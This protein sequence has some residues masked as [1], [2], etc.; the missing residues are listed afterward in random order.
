MFGK[1]SRAALLLSVAAALAGLGAWWG[2]SGREKP[3][4]VAAPPAGPNP[5]AVGAPAVPGLPAPVSAD[6]KRVWAP[7]TLYRYAVTLEHDVTF[8][9]GQPGTAPPSSMR[10]RIQGEWGVGVVAVS[11]DSVDARGQLQPA[12]FSMTVN[13]EEALA[14]DVRRAM[15][16]A[17]AAP[18]FMTLDR[19]GS[20]KLV[21]FERGLDALVQGLLRS[22]VGSTQFV[23]QGG[24]KDSWQAEELDST[25]QYTAA[26][27]R[28]AAAGQFEKVKQ[29][30]SRVATE[31]GLQP[32]GPEMRINVRSRATF[33]LAEDLWPRSLEGQEHLEVDTGASMPAAGNELKVTLRLLERRAD[34]TLPGSLDARRAALSTIP[35]ASFQGQAAD[36]E[37]EYR[38]LLAGKRFDDLVRDLR[39]MPAEGKARDDARTVALERLRALFK[40]EPSEALKVPGALRS[41]MDPTA[42][43]PMLGA[44]SAASTPES[45]K[46]LVQ[47]MDSGS[48]PALVRADAVAALGMAGEPT[49]EGVDALRRFTRDADPML[50]ETATLGLGNTALQMRDQDSR[51]AD[52]LVEE[53]SNAFRAA[54]TPAEQALLLSALGNTRSPGALPAIE[55]G[56]RSSSPVVRAAAVAALR[57]IPSPAVDPLLS[58]QLVGDPSPE[59]RKSAVFACSFRPLGPLL[60]ALEHALRQ[61]PADP[62]RAQVVNL[63]GSALSQVPQGIPLLQWA[64]QNDRNPEIRKAA[65]AFLNPGL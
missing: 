27:R 12:S 62:V 54:R 9:Q 32:L 53:L 40:L 47:S 29:S 56:L 48:L 44:L 1:Y 60:P 3:P 41:G 50:R 34:P 17:L 31:K 28:L 4:P 8:S 55:L 64:S 46:A 2:V 10:F 42:A 36:P 43:S 21:H 37:E 20:V 19:A 63:L 33:A 5:P 18:F 11:A 58:S 51:G 59:V 15:L 7:G 61:D 38:Q 16:A 22:L 13:G 45:I 24:P 26:Y 39:S 57:I 25:G 52:A 35:L 14:P 30:Y 49:Q 65:V 6:G 23:A